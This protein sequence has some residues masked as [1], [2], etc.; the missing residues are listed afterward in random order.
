MTCK[1]HMG[2]MLGLSLEYL[3]LSVIQ[4]PWWALP[5]IDLLLNTAY[6][7]LATSHSSS[8]AL[9]FY[10]IVFICVGF[11]TPEITLVL[12]FRVLG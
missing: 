3:R 4:D 6:L 10:M 5:R 9:L 7:Q 1:L 11:W 12:A 8:M 2:V